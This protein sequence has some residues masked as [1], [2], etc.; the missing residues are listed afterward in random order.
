MMCSV[1]SYH[2]FL[3]KS[4]LIKKIV[5][6]ILPPLQK[7]IPILKN[8]CMKINQDKGNYITSLGRYFLPFENMT[9]ILKSE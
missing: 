8:R 1:E 7:N 6:E 5:S 9:F 3:I 2:S 4:S